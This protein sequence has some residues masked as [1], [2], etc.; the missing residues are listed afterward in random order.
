MIYNIINYN[1]EYLQRV[2]NIKIKNIESLTFN[3]SMYL[4]LLFYK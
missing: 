1:S 2:L 4:T 3:F